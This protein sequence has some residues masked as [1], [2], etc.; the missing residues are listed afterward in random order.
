MVI[1][2]AYDN[3]ASSDYD[4]TLRLIQNYNLPFT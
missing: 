3:G 1:D 2:D 4:P